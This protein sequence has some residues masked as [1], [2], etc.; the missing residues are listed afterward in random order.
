MESKQA[1]LFVNKKKQKNFAPGGVGDWVAT[2]RRTKSFLLLFFKK[3]ALFSFRDRLLSDPRFHAF[4]ARFPLT[5]RIARREARA[6]F[7]VC[8]GFV[9]A[10]T[11]FACVELDLFEVLAAGPMPVAQIAAR[12]GLNETAAATLLN[13]AA[14]LRLLQASGE[15]FRLGPLGAALR[16]N[17]GVS[18]MVRH[19]RLFYADLADPVA[20]LRGQTDPALAKFWPYHSTGG[21]AA[22]YSALMAATQP[23]IA[24]EILA[25]YDVS[26]HACVLDV[27]GGDGSFL[28]AAAKRAPAARLLLFDL[29][30]V[31]AQATEKFTASG[32]THRA[33]AIGGDVGT[34]ALP[35]GA[36]L[37][38]LVR[39]LHDNDDAHALAILRAAR[40][41]LPPGGKILIAE[42][43]AGTGGAEPT[44][45]AYFGFYL[46]AMRS[47]RPR[48]AGELQN[49]LESAGF[50][51]IRAART[52]QP[53]LTSV[54]TAEV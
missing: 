46:T 44:G 16:G 7:D 38:T 35:S 36:D 8:A 53:M 48:T 2:A 32:L 52:N 5:R 23:M 31:A 33:Q 51:R 30:P 27:C 26:R 18:A 13:A 19:H 20:L 41:A 40:A 14:S 24:A 54:L 21:D 50:C 10:Q 1:L 22:G 28:C 43:L 12:I 47:G 49:L 34:D 37:V 42:P 39:V 45:A 6:L 17:P 25:A 9:Y 4:A 3:E 15:G 11:L 29:P